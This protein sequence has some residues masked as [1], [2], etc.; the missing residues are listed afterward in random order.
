MGEV[1]HENYKGIDLRSS[2]SEFPMLGQTKWKVHLDITFPADGTIS[3]LHEYHND[4]LIFLTSNEARWGRARMGPSHRRPLARQ[5]SD[6]FTR[7]S[8]WGAGAVIEGGWRAPK[9]LIRSEL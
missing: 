5:W 2:P 7:V 3:F 9:I 8:G 6:S 4:R 1:Q